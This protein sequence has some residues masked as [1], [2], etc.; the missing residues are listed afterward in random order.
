MKR[1]AVLLFML[2]ETIYATDFRLRKKLTVRVPPSSVKCFYENASTHDVIAIKYQVIDGNHGKLDISFDM[3]N[4][5]GYPM[6]TE[7]KKSESIHRLTAHLD[8]DYRYCFDNSFSKF[9]EKTVVFE[10]IIEAD[11]DDTKQV[12]EQQD[13][14]DDQFIAIQVGCTVT[15]CSFPTQGIFWSLV[16][17]ADSKYS[18]NR[19]TFA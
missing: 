1:F 6:V 15:F 11:D 9:N 16:S 17:C 14:L 5:N 2:A 10:I 13:I 8:G 19:H 12:D 3:Q 18:R 7:C 4:P